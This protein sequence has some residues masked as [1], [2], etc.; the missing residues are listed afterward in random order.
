MTNKTEYTVNNFSAV[1]EF[2]DQENRYAQHFRKFKIASL[3][4]KY[5]IYGS[6][7][8]VAIALLILS[9]GIAY[10]LYNNQ[11][12]QLIKISSNSVTQ[13]NNEDELEE[14]KKL[15]EDNKID[16]LDQIQKIDQEYVIF[17]IQSFILENED[18]A[19]V[20]TGWRYKPNDL[21][22]PYL[23]YC[24]LS[25]PSKPNSSITMTIQLAQKLK[26]E[27]IVDAQYNE[28]EINYFD[29]EAA[30]SQCIFKY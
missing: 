28:N 12:A 20:H 8:I 4:K 27:D 13:I 29:F 14:L 10:W 21:N 16:D 1:N 5:A 23:Q 18:Q 25:I 7:L 3:F 6:L 11:P 19:E 2:I 26:F 17:K 24:Y 30:K 15:A 22:Y 9:I